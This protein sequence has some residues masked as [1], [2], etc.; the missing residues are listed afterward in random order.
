MALL[1]EEDTYKIIGMCMEVYNELGYGFS[2]IIYKD[3]LEI[4]AEL[5]G[6]LVQREKPYQ[7]YYKTRSLKRKYN[8]DFVMFIDQICKRAGI[9]G[10][11]KL[12]TNITQT[13]DGLPN[14]KPV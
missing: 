6:I 7:V 9:I 12:R 13:S 4:E 1:R 5:N 10:I 14:N 2:E 3:A 8:A 11:K